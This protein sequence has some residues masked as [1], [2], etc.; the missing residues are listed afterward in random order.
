MRVPSHLLNCESVR[1]WLAL[2]TFACAFTGGRQKL[3][4]AY[5]GPPVIPRFVVD[6]A[7]VPQFPLKLRNDPDLQ[8]AAAD[9]SALTS[10]SGEHRASD[11]TTPSTSPTKTPS[12][13]RATARL[14]L[15]RQR[16]SFLRRKMAA[17]ASAEA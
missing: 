10:P 2:F 17:A 5:R 15:L 7:G 14:A 6:C 16:M 1:L 12:A 3:V 4:R 8:A 13:E 9:P 11:P